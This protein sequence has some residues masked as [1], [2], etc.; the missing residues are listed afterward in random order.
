MCKPRNPTGMTT[1]L[2][3]LPLR[4]ATPVHGEPVEPR[5]L[6]TCRPQPDPGSKTSSPRR[7]GPSGAHH[8]RRTQHPRLPPQ[9]AP[10]T[11]VPP[12]TIAP[13][14]QRQTT[15]LSPPPR[16]PR[17]VSTPTTAAPQNRQKSTPRCLKSFLEKTL[18]AR[19]TPNSAPHPPLQITPPF[20]S[21]SVTMLAHVPA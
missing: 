14:S 12:T 18:T 6:Q 21:C 8:A 15:L 4:L 2:S 19:E 5:L 16:P 20:A 9:P 7:P 13:D 17:Q 1:V 3:L 11:S 10:E